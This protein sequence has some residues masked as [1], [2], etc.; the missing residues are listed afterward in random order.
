M[1]DLLLDPI[2]HD[3]VYTDGDLELVS[4]KEE[5]AQRVKVTLLTQLTEWAFDQDF[6]VPYR[7]EILI[8]NFDLDAI[9]ARLTAV[10]AGVSGVTGVRDL[11]LSVDALTREL[12]V[13][14]ILDT[15]EGETELVI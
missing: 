13:S 2:T 5:I 1:T 11:T 14:A 9:Q 15:E 12:T 4:G 8:K 6:G 7:E 10:M 3:L